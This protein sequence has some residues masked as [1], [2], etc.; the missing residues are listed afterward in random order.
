MNTFIDLYDYIRHKKN[1]SILSFLKKS[2]NGKDK[3]ESLFRLFI[4]LGLNP[5]FHN[6]YVCDGNFNKQTIQPNLDINLLFQKNIKDK[7]DKSDLTLMHKTRK[8]LIITTS[9]NLNKYHIGDLDIRDIMLLASN[10]KEYSYQI[11]IVVK[12]KEKLHSIIK[13]A[14][15]CNQD[16]I[17]MCNQALI[18]DWDDLNTWYYNFKLNYENIPYKLLIKEQKSCLNLRFHQEY[19]I[20]RTMDI[21]T[22]HKH[23][24]WGHIPR[25]GKSY[26][27]AGLILRDSEYKDICNY[28]LITTAPNETISQYINIFTKTIQFCDFNVLNLQDK[29]HDFNPKYTKNIIIGSKQ[30]LDKKIGKK[31]I[32]WLKDVVFEIRFIDESHYGGTT[33]LA[34]QMLNLYGKEAFTVYIT[35]TY[36]KP[37]NAYHITP[38]TQ[39]L[40]TLEDINLCKNI[41]ILENASKIKQRY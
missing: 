6:Y 25:S 22:A 18:Y 29:K 2:W 27:M 17:D 35:A 34:Q 41:L 26:I 30:F 7:G 8:I 28:L 10:Y 15:S 16:I 33:E 20:R 23:A 39:V 32:D 1:T 4:Y 5:D 21:K 37:I 40:W 31:T 13:K 36:L 24:L 14:E 38:E 9:K 3:Q 11:C 12:N 19:A